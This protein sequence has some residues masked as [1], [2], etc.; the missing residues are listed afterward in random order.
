MGTRVRPVCGLNRAAPPSPSVRRETCSLA[1][2]K[3]FSFDVQ[4]RA[5][6]TDSLKTDVSLFYPLRLSAD[7]FVHR[8]YV[9]ERRFCL[10]PS[11]ATGSFLRR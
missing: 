4:S 8:S 1:A 6:I 11:V 5:L 2:F 9:T 3:D 10:A 7:G